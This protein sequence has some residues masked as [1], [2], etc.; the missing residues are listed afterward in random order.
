M[1]HLRA[2]ALAVLSAACTSSTSDPAPAAAGVTRVE[3]GAGLTGGPV[4]GTGT[5]AIAP[6]GVDGTLLAGGA[7]TPGHLSYDPATQAEL[8]THDHDASY[9]SLS[10]AHDGAYAGLSHLHDASYAPLSHAHDA[11]YAALAHGHLAA[12]V[13][14]F[15]ASAVAAMGAKAASNPL[16]HDRYTDAEALSAVALRYLPLAGGT[17]T[18][19]IDLALQ[20]PRNL[21]FE[22]AGSAPFA[23]GAAGA[24]GVYFDTAVKALRVCDGTAWV[25]VASPPA[26][27]SS[28]QSPAESC[29]TLRSSDPSLPSGAYWLDRDGAGGA[30]PV[31]GWCEMTLAGGGWTMLL[32]SVLGTDTLSFWRIPYTERLGRKGVASPGSN[33][34]DGELHDWARSILDVVEDLAGEQAILVH[35]TYGAFDRATMR[36]TAPVLVA[37]IPEVFA[38]HVAGGWSSADHDGDPALANCATTYAGVT[39]HYGGGCFVYQLGADG[40]APPYEDGGVGPH[41]QSA[42]ALTGGLVSDGTGHTRVRRITRFVR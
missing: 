29:A 11:S 10:H 14:D 30:A 9:A 6:G 34:Y 25:T 5:I 27:G 22:A 37:G 38:Q 17:L 18:G 12:G 23:C 13:S 28:P 36:F 24:G 8:D 2:A 41:L 31:Q 16:H 3:T 4:T 19:P 1:R 35:A 42:Y 15:A 40:D 26:E 7:V 39:Q 33:F 32:N 21:R 20:P